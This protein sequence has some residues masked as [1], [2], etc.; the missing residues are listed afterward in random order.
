MDYKGLPLVIA[1]VAA[2]SSCSWR[3]GHG[4]SQRPKAGANAGMSVAKEKGKEKTKEEAKEKIKREYA[5]ALRLLEQRDS[6]QK[7]KRAL[8]RVYNSP[9][10]FNEKA[11]NKSA[12]LLRRQRKTYRDNIYRFINAQEDFFRFVTLPYYLVS[13]G[14]DFDI[15]RIHVIDKVTVFY[16]SAPWCSFCKKYRRHLTTWAQRTPEVVVREIDLVSKHSQ[17]AEAFREL[18]RHARHQGVF[19]PVVFIYDRGKL[20]YS[21]AVKPLLHKLNL[22]TKNQN[23]KS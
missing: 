18:H 9:Y 8:A 5:R 10:L 13:K 17:A 7:A 1:L 21:G 4:H 22:L 11:Y 2:L 14:H 6:W 16:F 19:V 23:S 12:R 3:G 15:E 20:L